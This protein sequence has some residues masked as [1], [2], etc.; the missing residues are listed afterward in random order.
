[1]WIA[2]VATFA[3]AGPPPL[4][5][6]DPG[7][8]LTVRGTEFLYTRPDG[9]VLT[10]ADLLGATLHM[11]G[12]DVRIADVHDDA[13]A[14]GGRVV[15]HHLVIDGPGGAITELCN[16]DP[17]G[18]HLGFPVQDDHGSYALTCTSGA[19]GKCVRWGY[20]PWDEQPGGPPLRAL[21]EAC[22][23]M[24]RADYGGDGQT[25]T[26]DG[27]RIDYCDAYGI[28]VCE[29]ELD[30]SFEAAWGVDGA[31]CAARTRIP[32]LATLDALGARYP[33]LKDHL[34]PDRCK[35]GDW[36]PGVLLFDRV[37]NPR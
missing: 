21:H 5:G 29:P 9:T 23:K 36:R 12:L 10:S 22:V 6:A 35:M 14:K 24:V 20:R 15:L 25:Y 8:V 16:A 27:T 34:G 11:D 32:E 1:M 13:T 18:N 33:R 2:L 37:A 26:R 19:I 28:N 30:V 4:V 3:S 31:V 7:G 17:D